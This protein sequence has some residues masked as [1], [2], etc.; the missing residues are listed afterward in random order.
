[1]W[2]T[3]FHGWNFML[4]GNVFVAG[5]TQQ[6]ADSHPSTFECRKYGLIPC[7]AGGSRA[8]S[9]AFSTNWIMTMAARDWERQTLSLRSMLSAEPATIAQGRYPELFQQGETNRG[10]PL[11]D[12]Q[13]P[14]DFVMEMAVLYDVRFSPSFLASLYAAPIGDPAIGPTAYPH[15]ASATE[16]PIAPLGHFRCQKVELTSDLSLFRSNSSR[17]GSRTVEMKFMI[18]RANC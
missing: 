14:D 10:T 6:G 3:R 17:E 5:T 12:G 4:H 18:Q 8:A 7:P 16:N 9:G 13:H 2:M 1:M 11:I 15:R